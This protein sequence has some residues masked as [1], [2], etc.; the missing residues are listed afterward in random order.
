MSLF[1]KSKKDTDEICL[2]VKSRQSRQLFELRMCQYRLVEE[3]ARVYLESCGLKYC[4]LSDEACYAVMIGAAKASNH[5]KVLKDTSVD[6]CDDGFC[7]AFSGFL[8][9]VIPHDAFREISS[10]I[11]TQ[12]SDDKS[13]M[14]RNALMDKLGYT[15]FEAYARILA[16]VVSSY[17][18]EQEEK[19][20]GISDA[21]YSM[22]YE[23]KSNYEKIEE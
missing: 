3:L 2:C 10:F 22:Y 4:D 20:D 16:T 15:A 8:K 6:T 12:V 23:A 21:L 19:M 18:C 9:N 11:S 13:M 5:A 14:L 1:G 17:I 7:E